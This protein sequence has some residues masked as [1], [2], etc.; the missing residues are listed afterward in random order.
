MKASDLDNAEINKYLKITDLDNFFKVIEDSRGRYFFNLNETLFF[1]V[2]KPDL[3]SSRTTQKQIDDT[4]L[5]VYVCTCNEFWTLISYKLYGTTRLAWLL[6]K[7]NDV[8]ASHMFD[9]KKPGDKVWYLPRENVEAIVADL[10][11]FDT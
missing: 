5:A 2:Q 1:N 11:D 7:L 9:V 8:D 6:M 4:G 10:N 3:N